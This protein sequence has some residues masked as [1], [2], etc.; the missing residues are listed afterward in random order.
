MKVGKRTRVLVA[1]ATSFLIGLALAGIT[2]ALAGS[3]LKIDVR[4]GAEYD[5]NVI[6]SE[7][8]LNTGKGDISYEID[9]KL[10]FKFDLG[11]DTSMAFGYSFSQS[12]HDDLPA[13]DVQTH[14]G[15]FRIKHDFGGFRA[16]AT[17]YF[18]TSTLGGTDFLT[19][20]RISP[21]V[22]FKPSRALYLRAGYSYTDKNIKTGIG[23]DAK[24]HAFSGTANI[25]L[26]G[27]RTYLSF[28]YRLDLVDA[29]AAR[30]DYTGHRVSAHFITRIPFM[31]ERGKFRV[32]AT[33]IKRDYSSI[34]PSLG[35][36]R[37][38][39]KLTLK[40]SLN[41]PLGKH[42][43]ALGSYRYRD[44]QSNLLTADY[45]ESVISLQIGARF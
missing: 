18:Y 22:S 23:R 14:G 9:G 44:Y 11:S 25:L 31:G 39:E 2:P 43:Y 8:D 32:G 38:D 4:A 29:V 28:R 3:K 41:L 27:S 20:Q 12:L 34:T 19:L 7:T 35:V 17:Y 16:G 6:V 21:Y 15:K 5:S 10:D 42:L 24:T 1:T 13:F 30:Y 40:A 37:D 33:Y 26:N 36:P 45:K